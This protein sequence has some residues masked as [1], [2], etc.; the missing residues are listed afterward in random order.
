[1]NSETIADLEAQVCTYAYTV[2]RKLFFIE[3]KDKNT[4]LEL[5][6]NT[7]YIIK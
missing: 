3:S 4:Y 7:I 5:Q 2:K 1:M 6:F